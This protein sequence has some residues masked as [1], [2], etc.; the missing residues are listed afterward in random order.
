[1]KSLDFRYRLPTELLFGAGTVDRAGE[2][3]G[4]YGRR[5]LI[6]SRPARHAFVDIY[7]RVEASLEQ[8][9]ISYA[10][11]DGVVPNPTTDCVT[12]GAT[13]AR[14]FGADVILAVGGGSS[15]DVAKAVAVEAVHDGT[16][17]DY[18]FFRDTQPT[19]ATLPI[20]TITTTSGSGSHVT[21]ISVIS[22]A[23]ESTKSALAHERLFPRSSIV[24][25]ALVASTPSHVTATSGFDIFCH[26]FESYIHVGAQPFTDLMA[27]EAIR[28]VAAHLPRAVTDGH[29]EEAREQLAWAD[30]L[31]GMCIANTG[32]TLPHGIAMTISG[33]CPAVP[34]GEALAFVYPQVVAFTQASATQR[35]AA[36]ARILAPALERVSDEAA[37]ERSPAVVGEFLTSIGLWTNLRRY[38]VTREDLTAIADHSRDLGDYLNNPRIAE[39]DDIHEMLLDAYQRTV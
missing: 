17:W 19:A 22:K 34:H 3:V 37:A 14:E 27:L 24:D 20:V 30:T 21:H 35:F 8:A 18:L 16:S 38:D 23:Q 13:L 5:C 29:D 39:R 32:T 31:A 6:V 2:V 11:F 4:R 7:R 10:R 9:G 1:M 12:Q 15:M 33:R 25:P 36:M 26:A 28:L